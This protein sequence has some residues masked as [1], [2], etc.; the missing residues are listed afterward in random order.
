MSNISM[1]Y[2]HALLLLIQISATVVIALQGNPALEYDLGVHYRKDLLGMLTDTAGTDQ[3]AASAMSH[4]SS[5]SSTIYPGLKALGGLLTDSVF[6]VTSSSSVREAAD[7]VTPMSLG[8][9]GITS[10]ASSP[11]P[12][13]EQIVP[14]STTT[15]ST[16]YPTIQTALPASTTE[17]PDAENKTWQIIGISFIAI[18]LIAI[19]VTSSM[20]FDRW[21]KV[22]QQILCCKGRPDG[23]E[24]LVPD[25]EKQT[26]EGQNR[27]ELEE[28]HYNQRAPPVRSDAESRHTKKEF[29][30]SRHPNP[31][32]SNTQRY[33]SFSHPRASL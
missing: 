12:S 3:R 1:R 29:R 11:K 18:L 20:F 9:L 31:A 32:T 22:A 4:S 13:T 27:A 8:S 17:D 15:R 14:T 19:A 24:Q 26:W 2:Q 6:S 21:W 30:G 28:Y 25:W 5:T 33:R 23:V 7:P 10:F 16:S